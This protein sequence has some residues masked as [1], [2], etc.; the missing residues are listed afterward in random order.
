MFKST[1]NKTGLALCYPLWALLCVLVLQ[2]AAGAFELSQNQS[3]PELF[4][5]GGLIR[6]PEP[7][8]L[9]VSK[10]IFDGWHFSLSAPVVFGSGAM[11][12]MGIQAGKT[13]PL[14]LGLGLGF[15]SSVFMPLDF[16]RLY[17][18][19]S[20]GVSHGLPLGPFYLDYGL[21]YAGLFETRFSEL[22]PGSSYYHGPLANLG[23]R[24]AAGNASTYLGVQAGFYAPVSGGLTEPIWILQ[25]VWGVN[26]N[27]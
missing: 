14:G 22:N 17:L 3:Q 24:L 25:P 16:Q 11:P 12:T 6:L 27:L 2:P 15:S 1:F 21:R 18:N 5:R 13:F 7:Q 9:S 26:V 8:Q 10:S 20:L 23:L 4:D 19:S